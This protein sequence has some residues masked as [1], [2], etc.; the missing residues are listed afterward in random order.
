MLPAAPPR[1]PSEVNVA[2]ATH[3]RRNLHVC[4]HGEIQCHAYSTNDAA[5]WPGDACNSL[6]RL[7]MRTL[8]TWTRRPAGDTAGGRPQLRITPELWHQFC[9][10]IKPSR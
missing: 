3:R 5:L 2:A 7:K 4:N 1:S 9:N 8:S 10:G 6:S